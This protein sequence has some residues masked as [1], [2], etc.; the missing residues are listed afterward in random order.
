MSVRRLGV[1]LTHP[2]QYYSALFRELAQRDGVDLE[3]L[4]AH[5][6][7]AAEQ[8]A[9][10]GVEFSWDVDLTSGYAHRFLENRARRNRG[11]G[12]AGYD[13]PEVA[14]L[15][16]SGR[17]DAFVVLG[18]HARTYWQAM[19]A[20][21]SASVPVFVRGDSQLGGADE[22]ARGLAKKLTYPL[23]VR[24]FA[25]CL[26]TGTRSEAYFRHYGARSVVRSPHFVDNEW[27]ATRAAAVGSA[28]ARATFGLPGEEL[29]ILFAGKLVDRKRPVDVIEAAIRAQRPVS[30]LI[31]GDGALRGEC[32]AAAVRARAVGVTVSFAG[33]LNQSAIPAAYAAAD[34]I[35]LPSNDRESWGLV[36][37]EAMACGKP[38]IV[39]AQV[40]CGPDLVLEGR[41]GFVH[42]HG[43]VDA[44]AAAIRRLADDRVLTRELGEAARS[45]VSRYSASAAA[46]GVLQAVN[47]HPRA[48]RA[49]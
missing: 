25:A 8:G 15:I 12:F 1:L 38:A 43:D 41:T 10:F 24:R 7:T 47:A 34:V 4:Y 18:W 5:Q 46:D 14:G 3:V 29:V 21:W 36:V 35:A 17:Y 45:R 22:G 39:S 44:L 9:D 6:P 49:Q 32:E 27:F 16:R 20:C 11:G 2:V 37:N 19:R 31:A 23:F 28:A 30:V 13:T 26:A 42:P 48:V 33:F 40:G